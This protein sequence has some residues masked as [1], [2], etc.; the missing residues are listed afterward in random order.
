MESLNVC[1]IPVTVPFPPS[2]VSVSQNGEKSILISWIP[3]DG[4]EYYTIY[5][6]RSIQQFIEGA[7]DSITIQL[8][9]YVPGR[10]FQFTIFANTALRS[11]EVLVNFTL[12]T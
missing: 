11:V 4:A 9:Y 5:D 10:P 7:N 12:G 6:Y 3:S 2:N 8:S 1:R